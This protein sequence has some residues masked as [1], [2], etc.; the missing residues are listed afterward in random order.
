MFILLLTGDAS[1]YGTSYGI[2]DEFTAF[3]S[4][5][6]VERSTTYESTFSSEYTKVS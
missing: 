6:H 5:E 2:E 1:S 3:E 4:V